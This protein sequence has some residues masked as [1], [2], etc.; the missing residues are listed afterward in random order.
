MS[1][2]LTMAKATIREAS[3]KKLVL[4]LVV[5]TVVGIVLTG[6]GFWRLNQLAGGIVNG[7]PRLG[8][9]EKKAVTSQLLILVMFAFSFVLAI[10]TVFMAAPSIAGELESGV[11]AAVLTRPIRRVEMLAGKWTGLGVLTLAYVIV[12]SGLEFV[13]VHLATGYWPPHPVTFCLFL[14]GEALI[15]LTLTTL[16]STRMSSVTGGVVALGGFMLAWMGG[17]AVA[18]G[19]VLNNRGVATVGTVT[20]LIMPTDGLWRGAIFALEPAAVIATI[21]GGSRS[22]AAANP[23][24]AANAPPTPYVIW[25]VLWMVAIFAIATWSFSRREI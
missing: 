22:Q 23:F 17:I 25:A 13:A 2:V 19:Q 4:A 8:L 3:R 7:A 24:F 1:A 10:S 18:L 20:R 6:F 12:A 11:A 9:A 5:I 16:I 15:T 14:T 21:Q